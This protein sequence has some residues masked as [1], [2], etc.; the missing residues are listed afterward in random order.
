MKTSKFKEELASL[1]K[2]NMSTRLEE[3]RRELFSLRLHA[4]TQPVKDIMQFRK[5]RRNIARVLTRLKQ[6]D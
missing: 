5:L 6:I 2:E 1:P 4:A 3:L